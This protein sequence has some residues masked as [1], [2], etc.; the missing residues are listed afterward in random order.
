MI[1]QF[2]WPSWKIWT[3][4]LGHEIMSTLPWNIWSVKRLFKQKIRINL[5]KK[6][7]SKQQLWAGGQ[8]WGLS[9]STHSIR[10]LSSYFLLS[11]CTFIFLREFRSKFLKNSETEKVKK[12]SFLY[13]KD[14]VLNLLTEFWLEKQVA[15]ATVFPHIRPVST[16]H[17]FR[18]LFIKR[19]Q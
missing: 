8:I 4:S 1:H 6:F 15:S 14:W 3:L 18:G 19:S 12:I 13:I 5:G 17:F 10:T 16:Y 11:N 9:L 2:L 7:E